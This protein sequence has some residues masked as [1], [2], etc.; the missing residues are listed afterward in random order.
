MALNITGINSTTIKCTQICV[1]RYQLNTNPVT[2]VAQND[3]QMHTHTNIVTDITRQKIHLY[4]YKLFIQQL[5][6]FLIALNES[7]FIS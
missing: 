5:I 4:I 1:S 6:I 3:I 7:T 2:F